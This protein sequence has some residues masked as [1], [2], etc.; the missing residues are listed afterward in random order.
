MELHCVICYEEFDL[1]ERPPVVLPCGHTYVCSICA[2][3][4]K[5]CHECREPLYW[6]PPKQTQPQHFNNQNNI[7]RS[8]ATS[9]YSRYNSRYSP[10]TPPHPGGGGGNKPPEKREEVPLPCPK[11]VVLMEMIE[12]KQRQERLV[13][14]QKE[15]KH[16]KKQEKL[17]E[18]QRL[19]QQRREEKETLRLLRR[20]QQAEQQ[21]GTDSQEIEVDIDQKNRNS[22]LLD[23]SEEEEEE[24]DYEEYSDEHDYDDEISSSSSSALPLGDPEL[25]SGYAALS[26]TC[27]TYAV[28][29]SEGLVVLP[30]DPNRP[31]Y[32]QQNTQQQHGD[33][34][35][36][37]SQHSTSHFSSIFNNNNADDDQDNTNGNDVVDSSDGSST[38]TTTNTT[39]TTTTIRSS[40][41]R[42]EPFSIAEG[43][44]IQVVGVLESNDH[45]VYQLARGAGFVVATEK[46]LV[47]GTFVALARVNVKKEDLWLVSSFGLEYYSQF[48]V[49]FAN[50]IFGAF[51][52]SLLTCVF[53]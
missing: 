12:A 28:T 32:H 47:K 25:N 11:N 9:R 3:R 51:L 46:Q 7:H 17:L 50:K 13:T 4:I 41:S 21:Y 53:V 42:K 36:E 27:G 23:N 45:G 14:E 1:K 52:V 22:N 30:Q 19:A 29:E 31:K 18:K 5:I 20:Q 37:G 48:L 34:K 40:Q 6:N 44:K 26:G 15:A 33:E 39:T 24:T 35:N 8:P 49:S 2:K 38:N 10:S 16:Q 43:Q